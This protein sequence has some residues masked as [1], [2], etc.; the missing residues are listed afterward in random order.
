[1]ISEAY[2]V[3]SNPRTRIEYDKLILGIHDKKTFNNQ[4]A[5]EFYKSKLKKNTNSNREKDE[6]S[7]RGKIYYNT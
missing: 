2:E 1:M 6:F 4:D 3:L 5:Y 7:K